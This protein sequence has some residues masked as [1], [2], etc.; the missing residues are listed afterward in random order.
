MLRVRFSMVMLTSSLLA[1]G[2]GGIIGAVSMWAL[3]GLF[4]RYFLRDILIDTTVRNPD[5]AA[6]ARSQVQ[7]GIDRV[8]ATFKA[9][10]PL[11][12]MFLGSAK[13]AELKK[14]A[15]EEL[16]SRAPDIP[17]ET[18]TIAVRIIQKKVTMWAVLAGALVGA[19]TGI[20]QSFLSRY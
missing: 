11:V 15:V 18:F 8:V 5:L 4:C 10:I 17:P 19:I 9:K 6:M 20:L 13:E 1:A 16:L 2:M 14:V 12:G 3:F 7:Q